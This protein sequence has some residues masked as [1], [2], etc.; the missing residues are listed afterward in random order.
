MT[1][2]HDLLIPN[3]SPI[4]QSENTEERHLAHVHPGMKYEVHK[5]RKLRRKTKQKD[6]AEGRNDVKPM[7]AITH[8]PVVLILET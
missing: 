3:N 7:S 5:Q 6:K 1:T 8:A 2:K 4:I